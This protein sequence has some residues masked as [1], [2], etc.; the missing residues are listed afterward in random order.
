LAQEYVLPHD[1]IA[2]TL[3]SAKTLK[4]PLITQPGHDGCGEP[5]CGTLLDRVLQ[6]ESR[7]ARVV[8]QLTDELCLRLPANLAGQ[9]CYG[10]VELTTSDA[11][12]TLLGSKSVLAD[13]VELSL[14]VIQC[15][16]GRGWSV[17]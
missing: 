9:T 5:A 8:D 1:L 7:Q 11:N 16:G 12:R 4:T 13:L 3:T 15:D 10:L 6:C 17:S 14:D 2:L